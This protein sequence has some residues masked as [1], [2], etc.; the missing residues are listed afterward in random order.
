MIVKDWWCY[1]GY[2]WIDCWCYY[3]VSWFSKIGNSWFFNEEIFVNEFW[4]SC[5]NVDELSWW[6]GGMSLVRNEFFYFF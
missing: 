3:V 2:D 6:W 4:Y 5:W 1:D